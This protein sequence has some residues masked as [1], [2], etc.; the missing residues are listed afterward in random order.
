MVRAEIESGALKELYREERFRFD[1][2][3]IARAGRILPRAARVFLEQT[4]EE[5]RR[6]AKIEDEP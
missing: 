4:R 5:L 1:L 3:L 6:D 2:R